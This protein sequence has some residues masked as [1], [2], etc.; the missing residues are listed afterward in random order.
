MRNVT[1]EIFLS[2]RKFKLSSRDSRKAV[3]FG[4]DKEGRETAFSF[5]EVATEWSQ[6]HSTLCA[7]LCG[8]NP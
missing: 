6:L 1:E 5:L 2:L 7:Q 4:H 3:L 8:G